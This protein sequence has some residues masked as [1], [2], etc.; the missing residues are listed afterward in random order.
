MTNQT[1]RTFASTKLLA[2]VHPL[3]AIAAAVLIVATAWFA[4]AQTGTPVNFYVA[5]N[6]NDS[7]NGG[8][9]THGTGN[10]GPFASLAKAKLAAEGF[11]GSHPVTIQVR[12]GTYYLPL[13]PTSPGTLTL[14]G[15]ADSGTAIN[16]ITW[17]NYSTEVPVVSGGVPIG[18]GGLGL[19]WTNPSSGN[20]WR[21]TLPSTIQPFE[22]LFYALGTSAAGSTRRLR[23]RIQDSSGVGYYMN[24]VSGVETCYST[25]TGAPAPNISYCNFGTFLRVANTIAYDPGGSTCTLA[26]SD[27]TKC[28]DRFVYS[29]SS[30][31]P[32]TNWINLNGAPTGPPGAPCQATTNPYPVGDIGLTHVDAWTVDA[33]RVGCVDTTNQ[34]IY[35]NAAAKGNSS[36]PN[37]FGPAVGH[38]YIIENTKD[39]FNAAGVAGQTGLWFLDRSSAN[40]SPVLY[41]LASPGESPNSDL[42]VIPQ[43]GGQ[44][45]QMVGSSESNDYV[46]A[47]LISASNLSHVTFKGINFEVDNFVPS[48]TTGFSNDANGEMSVPQ[49]ID[50]ENCQFVTFDTIS[51]KRT[52]ASGI[53]IASTS[54]P[55]SCNASTP[56]ALIQNSTFSDI[57]DSGIRIGHYPTGNDTAASVVQFVTAQNNLIDGYSRVFPDGEGIAEGNGH[58]INYLHNDIVDGYHAGISV[59]QLTCPPVGV[60][61]T[62][63]ISKYNHLRN[64]MQGITSDGGSLYYNVG[65]Q[66]GSGSGDQIYNNLVHD[67]SDA[68]IIDVANGV[69]L[70]P[71]S[72]YGGEGIYLDAQSGGVDVEN[73]VVYHVSAYTAWMTSGPTVLNPVNPNTFTN[74]IFSLGILGMFGQQDP[75]PFLNINKQQVPS[76]GSGFTIGKE[77]KLYNNIFNFDLNESLP[78]PTAPPSFHVVWGCA[79]SC[80]QNYNQFQDF[81]GNAYWRAG[82]PGTGPLF[83]SVTGAVGDPSAFYV[84]TNPPT[85]AAAAGNNCPTT[86][87]SSNSN[88]FTFLTFD[89]PPL[90][91]TWQNGQPPDPPGTPVAMGEDPGGTC[92]YNPTFGT[93]GNPGDYHIS[94]SNQPPTPFN[95]SFTNDTI[96]NAGR[97]SGA[98]PVTVPATFPTYTYSNTQF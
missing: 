93:T 21:V 39:A 17:E 94:S 47:S 43:L 65:G 15:P 72:G 66:N 52:S 86:P 51:V 87:N 23:S 50:C 1:I 27:G 4:N 34:I 29:A 40:A 26:N 69:R 58:D 53:L 63:I 3:R 37:F 85:G 75:W 92:I 32:I 9:P 74:N 97:T 81:E 98:A 56:C 7:W 28:L 14:S 55:P 71:G 6:G 83:C 77:V 49:A 80:G 16:P 73:N 79:D 70:A 20:L 64:L 19:T 48:Y 59:C 78:P 25:Q 36:L 31:D 57:G 35:L 90:V 54:G 18:T 84:L 89:S 8:S 62:N 42:V 2:A 45:P 91:K 41:Y 67:T 96:T 11:A 5:T 76:C 82:A 22:Y 10:N 61:G 60:N 24:N 68:S 38:R 12:A 44:F 88:K 46:G 95:I 33:M 30:P 13:S